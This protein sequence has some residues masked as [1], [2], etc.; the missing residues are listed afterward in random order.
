MGPFAVASAREVH[1]LGVLAQTAQTGRAIQADAA[2]LACR[3]DKM[4]QSAGERLRALE[5]EWQPGRGPVPA[6]GIREP[7]AAAHAPQPRQAER[8]AVQ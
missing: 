7:A 1:R 3:P 2:D 8:E 4:L 6:S 5:A